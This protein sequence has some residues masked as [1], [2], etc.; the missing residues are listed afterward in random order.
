MRRSL[1]G[2]G[3]HGVEMI[4]DQGGGD[5]LG[6]LF[7][8]ETLPPSHR[9]GVKQVLFFSVLYSLS[10]STVNVKSGFSEKIF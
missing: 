6:F 8:L 3:I 4:Y 10:A 7:S 5:F 9:N 1:H 2:V